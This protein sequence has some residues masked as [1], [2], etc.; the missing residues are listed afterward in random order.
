MNKTQ[1]NNLKK[2]ILYDNVGLIIIIMYETTN[3]DTTQ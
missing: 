3:N 2:K 1:Y